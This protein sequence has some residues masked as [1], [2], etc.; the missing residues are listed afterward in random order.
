MRYGAEVTKDAMRPIL[1][2]RMAQN[3]RWGEQNHSP[4]EWMAILTEEVGEAMR[5]A[6]EHHWNGEHYFH[7]RG[8]VLERY[9]AELIQVAAVAVA[10]L[11]S[12][13]RNELKP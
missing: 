7:D 11:E 9:R 4:M 10:A 13:D 3:D 8:A 5:E 2:E 6:L 1:A 12:L